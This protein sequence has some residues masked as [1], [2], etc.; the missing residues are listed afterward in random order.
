[1]SRTLGVGQSENDFFTTYNGILHP[2]ALIGG[3]HRYQQKDINNDILIS[4]GYGDGGGG[5]TRAMLETSTRME[6]GIEGLPKVRQAFARTYFDE[7]AERVKDN[8]R[9]PTWE[10]ELYFEYHRGTYTSMA[11]NKR[12]NRKIELHMMD[13]ELLSLLAQA[14]VA[15][16]EAE[17]DKL[18][19]GILINQFH[20]ILPG[21]SIHEVYEVTKKRVCRDGSR[22]H[23]TARGAPGCTDPRLGKAL[24]CTT[25]P[26]FVRSDVV[27]LGDCKAEALQDEAGNIYPVPKNSRWCRGVPE[28]PACQGQQNVCGRTGTGFRLRLLKLR[29]MDIR[30]TP[31]SILSPLMNTVR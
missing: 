23:G 16:P 22:N 18:W 17:I 30:L 11:R 6:K 3:W 7:L 31:R 9:L 29:P 14:K 24:P 8:R 10:G 15:Y 21:S 2:D 4:Y 26:A 19:H 12:S 13:L 27:E 1:M 5:P 20:D 28:Q 25:L